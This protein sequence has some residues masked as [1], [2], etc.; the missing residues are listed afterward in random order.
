M[1]TLEAYQ[2]EHK[3]KT[4]THSEK[5]VIYFHK[6]DFNISNLDLNEVK[7]REDIGFSKLQVIAASIVANEFN[8][9]KYIKVN[10][11]D[12]D[13]HDTNDGSRYLQNKISNKSIVEGILHCYPH[14]IQQKHLDSAKEILTEL[15]VDFMFKILSEDMNEF[16]QSIAGILSSSD[17]KL[18][19]KYW[20]T[21]AYLPTYTVK[22][23]IDRQISD[24]SENSVHIKSERKDNK[25]FL[26]IE[27]IRVSLSQVYGGYNVS[28]MT[29]EGNR[30]SFYS[31]KEDWRDSKEKSFKIEAKVKS[32]GQVWKKEHIAETRL[33][34]VKII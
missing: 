20:G 8:E 23:A 22:K 24:K 33:N 10:G 3:G 13:F 14:L 18:E 2:L 27:V 9:E 5:N 31:S 1:T 25:V 19:R 28:A 4:H 30:V 7:A 15:E 26:G 16:E 11:G 29:T 12:Y 32:H 17:N 21:C 6:Y 34:Y